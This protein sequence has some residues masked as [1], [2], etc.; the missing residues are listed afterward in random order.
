MA[1]PHVTGVVAL[2]LD[3][4]GVIPPDAMGVHL[5]RTG[6]AIFGVNYLLVDALL[7]VSTKPE[8]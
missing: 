5:S 7:A 1:A 8:P 2:V 4:W 3:N 6:E